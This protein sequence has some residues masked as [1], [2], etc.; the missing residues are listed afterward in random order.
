MATEIKMLAIGGVHG[1]DGWFDVALIARRQSRCVKATGLVGHMEET[2]HSKMGLTAVLEGIKLFDYDAKKFPNGLTFEI[3]VSDPYV[4]Q[5][6]DGSFDA[7]VH[8]ELVANIRMELS[9]HT[10]TIRVIPAST[11]KATRLQAYDQFYA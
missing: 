7:K 2:T 5:V 8:K 11:L 6:L 1:T 9:H 10:V 4:K 3:L